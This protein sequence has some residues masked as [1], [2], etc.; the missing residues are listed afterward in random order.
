MAPNLLELLSPARDADI[1]IEAIKHGAD[2]VYIGGPAF[3]ARAGAG[4]AVAD[5]SR[6]TAYAHR[7]HA[8]TFVAF[9]TIF[10][11][12]EIEQ[13]RKLIWELYDAGVDALI[14]QDM[15]LLEMDLPPIQLHASTQTDIRTPE[16]AR[17][18]QDV[19]FSQIVLARELTLDDIK[20]VRAAT[21]PERCTLEFFIHGALC[22]AFSGQC[23]ISHAH[24]GRSA[25]RGECSQ[26]CRLPYTLEDSQGRIVAYDKHLLS[27]KDNDQSNNLRALI[28]AGIRSFKIEGRYKDMA[29][30]KNSTAHYRQL[31]DAIMI[32]QPHYAPASSGG[33]THQFPPQPEKTFNRSTTDYFVHGRHHSDV[34]AFDTPKFAGEPIGTITRISAD[35]FEI[36]SEVE[37]HNGDGVSYQ[38]PTNKGSDKLAGMRINIVQGS[39]LFPNEMPDDLKKGQTLYRNRDQAF[40]R[41]LEKESA[42]R[43]I[44]VSMALSA[45][46][47]GLQLTLTDADGISATVHSA[48][49]IETA[50]DTEKALASL[51]SNLAKLGNTDFTAGDIDIA[52]PYFVPSSVV[53]GLRRDGIAVLAAAR[54]A[55][56][57]RLLRATP[58]EP[59]VPYPDKDLTY[60]GNVFNEHARTFY[61]KHGVE[62]IAD[63]YEANTTAG[64]VSVMITK[65]CLRYSFNLCP[66]EAKD[67]QL[68]GVKAEPMTLVNG[69][70]RL[71][72]RFDCKACEMHVIGKMKKHRVIPVVPLNPLH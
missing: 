52:G 70:E 58:L 71:T 39:R 30:V 11:D 16:K 12:S 27:M 4:N 8:R 42:E 57:P 1:G 69:S 5:I 18:L 14:V 67:W 32:E 26:A 21:D 41:S 48:G 65:H 10:D 54:D 29:Y 19:G 59:P 13:A 72:L 36:D 38:P 28:S 33:T 6:L 40:E 50:R 37:L 44:N 46:D 45:G 17:F 23:Y 53:N 43:R 20:R 64:D 7:F 31:L 22:V 61:R 63:A 51:R 34:G 68:K 2:A 9:N 56:R 24:T 47:E 3:G 60:L 66:K 15:G 35:W 25:N 55:Q 49:A 62:L